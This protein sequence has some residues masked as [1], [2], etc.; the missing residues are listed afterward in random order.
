MRIIEFK[1]SEWRPDEIG[2]PRG[3]IKETGLCGTATT[4]NDF[5]AEQITKA[6][7]TYDKYLEHRKGPHRARWAD[8]ADSLTIAFK[9][10]RISKSTYYRRLRQLIV[11]DSSTD[12]RLERPGK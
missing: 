1:I 11:P 2:T 3:A 4:E 10:G 9:N 8:D 6:I 7:E 5:T 12:T